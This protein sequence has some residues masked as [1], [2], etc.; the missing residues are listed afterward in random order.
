MAGV[1]QLV[2]MPHGI[3]R[4]AVCPIGVLFLRQVGF[5]Y[6]FENQNCRTLRHPVTDTRAEPSTPP[7]FNTHYTLGPAKSQVSVAG[8]LRGSSLSF[9]VICYSRG[10][11]SG[12]HF[13][14]F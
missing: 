14:S 7:Y 2:D 13:P 6:W 4:A 1:E 12:S 3:Q 9:F 10:C 5:E 11:H 8:S